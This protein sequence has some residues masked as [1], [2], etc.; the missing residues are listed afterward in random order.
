MI[1]N[2]IVMKIKESI[3]QKRKKIIV[4]IAIKVWK[5]RNSFIY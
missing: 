5:T 3:N 4:S 1:K 2:G